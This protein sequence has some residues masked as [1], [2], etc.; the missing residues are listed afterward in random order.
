MHQ[1]APARQPPTKPERG[2]AGVAPVP[3]TQGALPWDTRHAAF[4]HVKYLYL[5]VSRLSRQGLHAAAAAEAEG[6]Q[7]GCS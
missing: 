3:R 2:S 6:S 1:Q 5:M 4:R 7:A